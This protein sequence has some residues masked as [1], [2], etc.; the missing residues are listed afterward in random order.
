MRKICESGRECVQMDVGS[1]PVKSPFVSALPDFEL[2]SP[3]QFNTNLAMMHWCVVMDWWQIFGVLCRK[4][5]RKFHSTPPISNSLS[6]PKFGVGTSSSTWRCDFY[7]CFSTRGSGRELVG[8]NLI[9]EHYSKY[10]FKLTFYW[11]QNFEK[12]KLKHLV[13]R[14]ESL[15]IHNQSFRCNWVNQWAKWSTFFER[16]SKADPAKL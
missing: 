14:V 3:S 6:Q 9:P 12:S 10:F 13:Q 2:F 11:I 7:E 16:T 1:N 15:L 8:R 4:R 5:L